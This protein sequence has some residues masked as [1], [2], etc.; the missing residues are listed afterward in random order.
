VRPQLRTVLIV[1]SVI[2]VLFAGLG[3]TALADGR[4]LFGL[5][6]IALAVMNVVLIVTIGRRARARRSR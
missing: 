3:V 1:R 2:A 6:A 5:F 4:T